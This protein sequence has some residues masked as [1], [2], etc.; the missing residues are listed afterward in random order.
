MEIKG[1]DGCYLY[2]SPQEKEKSIEEYGE[3]LKMLKENSVR[4]EEKYLAIAKGMKVL[5]IEDNIACQKLAAAY[6]KTMGIKCLSMRNGEEAITYMEKDSCDLILVDQ[7]LPDME[8][9]DIVKTLRKKSALE[10]SFPPVI[11]M[12]SYERPDM[13]KLL[14]ESG[15]L[16]Y[17]IKPIDIK[18]IKR[19][20]LTYLKK[21]AAE[22]KGQA[23][24][25]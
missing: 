12:I 15:I 4:Q 7:I 1:Q 8:G 23:E 17:M 20:L 16:D 22:A 3:C 13:E 21:E 25:P 19:V 11:M 18:Q 5:L 6:L 14:K 9:T 2:I 24:E 10:N